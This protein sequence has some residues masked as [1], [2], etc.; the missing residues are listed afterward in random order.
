MRTTIS[1]PEDLLKTAQRLSGSKGY[2]EAIVSS[3]RDYVLLKQRLRYLDQLFSKKS[4]H[5]LK[6]IKAYRK[7]RQ[8]SS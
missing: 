7:K 6:K 5:S 8:W 1:I 4:P 3:L 2:S